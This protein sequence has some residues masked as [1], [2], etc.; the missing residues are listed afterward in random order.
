MQIAKGISGINPKDYLEKKGIFKIKNI[1]EN[2]RK[3]KRTGATYTDFSLEVESL[4]EENKGRQLTL[5]YLFNRDFNA[6]IDAFTTDTK[7]WIDRDIEITAE[8]DGEYTRWVLNQA[9][10]LEETIV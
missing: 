10:P 9:N 7:E 6:L 2:K 8:Q 3:S 1:I 4:E 5:M